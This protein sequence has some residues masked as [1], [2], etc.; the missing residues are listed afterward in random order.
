MNPFKFTRGR[1]SHEYTSTGID[2]GSFNVKLV[3]LRLNKESAELLELA[4]ESGRVDTLEVLKKITRSQDIKRVNTSFSGPATLIRYVNFP[5][6]S[7]NELKQALKFEAQKHI[8]FNVSEVNLD[9][10]I[11]NNDL[12]DNKML[13]LLA[14]VKKDSVKERLKLFENSGLIANLIDLDSLALINAFNFNYPADGSLKQKAIALLNIG[15]SLTNLNILEE[16][17]PRL[18][19]DLHLGGNNFTQKLSDLIGVDTVIAEGLKLKPDQ[20]HLAKITAGVESVLANLAS[21]IRISF[22]YY[23]S[24]CVSSVEKIFLSGGGSLFPGFKDMLANLL[25]IEVEHWDPLKR[26]QLAAN[27]DTQKAKSASGY[28]A[29]AVGLALRQVKR[30]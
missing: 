11:L 26:I 4:V 7:D 25:G 24:Q 10:C 9:A 27:I 3:K 17:L 2:F 21:E 22:D 12:P 20:E 8:P 19:R 6:M 15:A 14:A 1:A 13:V 18:S 16:G 30:R 5:R 23:E 28:L 29:I